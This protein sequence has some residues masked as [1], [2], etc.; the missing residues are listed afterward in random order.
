MEGA[1]VF[2]EAGN[3]LPDFS[4]FRDSWVHPDEPWL[5]V[6]VIDRHD[7]VRMWMASDTPWGNKVDVSMRTPFKPSIT[8]TGKGE[9]C[10]KWATRS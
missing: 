9:A 5:I 4:T 10:F 3:G 1:T 6:P 8:S 2:I 7:L